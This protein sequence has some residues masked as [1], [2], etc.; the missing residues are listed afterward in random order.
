MVCRIKTL[1]SDNGGEFCSNEFE[2]FLSKH[3]IVHKKTNP[4]TPEQNG[5]IERMNRSIV[6]KARCLLFDANLEKGFFC[7]SCKYGGLPKKQISCCRV[8]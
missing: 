1:R 6:E 8:I 5:V 3:G 2:S 4:H 7:G